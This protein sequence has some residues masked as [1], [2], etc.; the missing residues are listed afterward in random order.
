MCATE[1]TFVS[2]GGTLNHRKL[3]GWEET[4]ARDDEI[5]PADMHA[6]RIETSGSDLNVRRFT[7]G[8]FGSTNRCAAEPLTGAS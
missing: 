6:D 1:P 7:R 2:T 8:A 5:R 3:V 4:M